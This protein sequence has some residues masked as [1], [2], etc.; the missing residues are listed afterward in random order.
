MRKLEREIDPTDQEVR[1]SLSSASLC[2]AQRQASF[3][4]PVLAL[5]SRH[6][7]AVEERSRAQT[8]T[9]ALKALSV[10]LDRLE[11]LEE[12]VY[13]G[14]GADDWVIE[15]LERGFEAL[16]GHEVLEGTKVMQAAVVSERPLPRSS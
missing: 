9:V 10:Y 4:P 12:A 8:H 3:L 1:R 15:E 5:L 16:E 13:A 6:F 11:K 2:S 7:S 14:R